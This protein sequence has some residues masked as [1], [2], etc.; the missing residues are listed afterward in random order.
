VSAA[1]FHPAAS[2]ELHEAARFYEERL[3]GLGAAFVAEVERVSAF[4]VSRPLAG[5]SLGEQLRRL[6]VR[7]FPYTIIYRLARE[8]VE[9]I[10][11]AHQHRR[12]GYWRGRL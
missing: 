3:S 8:D 11:V 12:P 5:A 6:S 4:V 10:A 7:R 2:A 9:I 1:R